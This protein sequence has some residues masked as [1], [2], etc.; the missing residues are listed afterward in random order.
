MMGSD[1]RRNGQTFGFGLTDQLYAVG[2]ADMSDVEPCSGETGQNNVSGDHRFFGGG[3]ISAEPQHRRNSAFVHIAVVHQRQIF[4]MGDQ[5][6]FCNQA[7]FHGQAHHA[8]A[9]HRTSVIGECHG[10]GVGHGAHFRQFLAFAAFGDGADGINV[11]NTHF[12]SAVTN[13]ENRSRAVGHGSGIGHREHG[14]KTAGGRRPCTGGNGFFPFQSRFSQ[15]AVNIH[16]TGAYDHAGHIFYFNVFRLKVF[17]D[18]GDFAVTDQNIRN[19]IQFLGGID[20][21]PA[22]QQ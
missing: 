11:Y 2:G 16:K 5:R 13:V 8:A 14:G 1:L 22:F 7:V 21:S 15:M 4:L 19:F 10:A 9:V 6:Q 3:G 17:A 12:F 20:H 18:F